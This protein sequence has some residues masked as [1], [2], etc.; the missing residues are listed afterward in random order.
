MFSFPPFPPYE[1]LHPLVVH[2]PL[3]LLLVAWIPML[4][5]VIDNKRRGKWMHTA[6]TLLVIGTLFT[7]AAVITGEATEKIIGTT[8]QQIHDAVHE[9]EETA[10]SARNYFIVTTVL[11][12]FAV[13]ARK[14]LEASKKKPALIVI[15]ILVALGYTLGSLALI[16]AG[17][18]GGVLVHHHGI[19]A[20]ITPPTP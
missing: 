5:C 16:N 8:T 13:I 10:E 18:Q 17:H 14:Q 3:G 1:G 7:F 19:H 12:C 11:F 4:L 2:F 6:L 9:H 20:P 15:A